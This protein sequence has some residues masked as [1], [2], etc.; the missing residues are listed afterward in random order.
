MFER[1]SASDLPDYGRLAGAVAAT[2]ALMSSGCK[3]V[4][5]KA[6]PALICEGD[7]SYD[8]TTP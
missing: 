3:S 4:P 8:K 7:Q 5:L 6:K 1:A 2:T